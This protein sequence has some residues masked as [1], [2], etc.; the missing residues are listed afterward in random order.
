VAQ[1]RPDPVGQPHDLDL[2][3]ASRWSGGDGDD[4]IILEGRAEIVTDRDDLARIDA[5]YREK[6]VD[7]GS[8]ASATIFNEGDDC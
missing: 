6:Y 1:R 3:D 8:G 4:A 7:P 2:D 5:A